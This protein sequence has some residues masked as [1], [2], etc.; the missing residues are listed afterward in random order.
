MGKIDFSYVLVFMNRFSN[1]GS[2]SIEL[3]YYFITLLLGRLVHA[4]FKTVLSE[5]SNFDN[6]VC[7][8]FS[9]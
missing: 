6:D 1:Q 5:G 4:Q 7:C 3:E 8:F 9:L 2:V